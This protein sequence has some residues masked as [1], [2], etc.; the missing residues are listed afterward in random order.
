M[1]KDY[2]TEEEYDTMTEDE[3]ENFKSRIIIEKIK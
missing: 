3:Y 1:I 2:W